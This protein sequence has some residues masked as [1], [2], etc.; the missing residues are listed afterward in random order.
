MMD[1]SISFSHLSPKKQPHDSLRMRFCVGDDCSFEDPAHENFLIFMQTQSLRSSL[2][3]IPR[4]SLPSM[5]HHPLKNIHFVMQKGDL[6]RCT[7]GV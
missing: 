1:S 6:E 2:P 5:L 3:T 4:H 7:C